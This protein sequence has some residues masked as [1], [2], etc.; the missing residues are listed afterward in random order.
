MTVNERWRTFVSTT[1]R[2]AQL[3][4]GIILRIMGLMNQNESPGFIF[5]GAS[6]RRLHLRN[7]MWRLWSGHLFQCLCDS[8]SS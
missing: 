2:T 5:A 4:V 8:F 6:R 3:I 7:P 1:A